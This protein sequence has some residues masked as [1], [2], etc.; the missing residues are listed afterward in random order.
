MVE[1]RGAMRPPEALRGDV[2]AM[3]RHFWKNVTFNPPLYGADILGSV[4]DPSQKHFSIRRLNDFLRRALKGAGVH[5]PGV[6]EPYL[7]VG[8]W[9]ADFAWHTEDMDINS[10]NYIHFGE[11]KTWY[12]GVSTTRN[13]TRELR[14]KI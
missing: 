10:V 3:E 11:S 12:V 9:R 1:Q 14:W 4:T 7:Y 13:K 6:T 2:D 8:S 5:I